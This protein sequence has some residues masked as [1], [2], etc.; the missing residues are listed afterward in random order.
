MKLKLTRRRILLATLVV[1]GIFVVWWALLPRIDQRFVG[2]WREQHQSWNW[3]GYWRFRSDGTGDC[4]NE[5]ADGT[6]AGTVDRF[7]WQYDG[8]SIIFS[9]SSLSRYVPTAAMTAYAR[10]SRT[11]MPIMR[12]AAVPLVIDRDKMRV[13]YPPI[14][15]TVYEW[16]RMPDSTRR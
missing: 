16:N 2:V 4:W 6:I 3:S 5:R 13:V 10:L 11:P 14:L 9:E 1:V 15:D 12:T 7:F 8:V